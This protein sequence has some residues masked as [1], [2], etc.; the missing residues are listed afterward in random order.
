MPI[1]ATARPSQLA[2]PTYYTDGNS[3]ELQLKWSRDNT[4][5]T[6]HIIVD[7][8]KRSIGMSIRELDLL[9]EFLNANLD[10]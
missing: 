6:L 7:G 10:D 5:A 1:V 9:R 8:S 2:D 4:V 3:I